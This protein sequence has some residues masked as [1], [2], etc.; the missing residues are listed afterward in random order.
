MIRK[1]LQRFVGYDE[2]MPRRAVPEPD[3]SDSPAWTFLSNHGHVLVCIARNPDALLSEIADAVG[4]RERA[5]HRIVSDL[6]NEGYVERTREGRRNTYSVD[7]D[8]PLR[9]SQESDHTVGDLLRVLG[10]KRRG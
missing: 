6:V 9:H 3:T 10:G 7:R 5:A 8:Q 4:I 2:N 1:T